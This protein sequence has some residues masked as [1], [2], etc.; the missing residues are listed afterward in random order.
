GAVLIPGG[1]SAVVLPSSLVKQ[2][3]P[4][5]V[6]A[7]VA[8]DQGGCCENSRP[9]THEDPVFTV[10]GVI[11]YC[12][13]NIPGAVPVTASEALNN[14]TLP[15]IR[16]FAEDGIEESLRD[17]PHLRNGLNIYQGKLTRRE[18]GKDLGI[19]ASTATELLGA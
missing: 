7:D 18:V 19:D 10:D 4:G 12:V 16:K 15:V 17:D 14:A 8:I 11:H 1:K 13:A 5:S 3:R 6:I 2:M 9:T